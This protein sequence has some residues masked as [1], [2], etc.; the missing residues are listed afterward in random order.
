MSGKM[1]STR[2]ATPSSQAH[3]DSSAMARQEQQQHE[4]KH[5]QAQIPQSRPSVDFVI[6]GGS[7]LNVNARI[8]R[9]Q[10]CDTGK[11]SK[12]HPPWF[13]LGTQLVHHGRK[14]FMILL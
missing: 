10:R 9:D 11:P 2:S 8:L 12:R 14:S 13:R 7:H 5:K 3:T 4:A 6:R 1:C